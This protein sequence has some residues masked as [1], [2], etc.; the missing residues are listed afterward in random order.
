MPGYTTEAVLWMCTLGVSRVQGHP[1]D[2]TYVQEANGDLAWGPIEV[3]A[4]LLSIMTI[5]PDLKSRG[6]TGEGIPS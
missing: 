2:N 3:R 1:Q 4:A 6:Q 5:R